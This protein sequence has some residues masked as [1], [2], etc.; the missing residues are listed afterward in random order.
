MVLGLALAGGAAPAQTAAPIA[1]AAPAAT[2][3]VP[4]TDAGAPAHPW[5]LGDPSPSFE[6]IHLGDSEDRVLAVLGPPAPKLPTPV[7]PPIHVLHYRHGALIVGVSQTKGVVRILLRKPEGGALAGIRVGDRV[8]AVVRLWGDPPAGH[9]SVGRFPMG[10]W[11][12]IVRADMGTQR[13]MSIVLATTA[14]LPVPPP[15]VAVNLGASVPA[16]H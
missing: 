14:F 6:G 8:G 3:P 1:P 16:A 2:H 5:R 10:P 9:G 12:V 13:V 15:P 4:P 7:D 11:T